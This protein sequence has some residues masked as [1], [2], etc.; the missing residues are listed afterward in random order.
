MIY[1]HTPEA[2]QVDLL[3]VYGKD[4]DDNLSRDEIKALCA[5]AR[6][7]REQAAAKA[8]RARGR[9]KGPRP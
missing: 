7:L 1:L 6:E 8:R 2:G 5:L 4:E 3:T 9:R